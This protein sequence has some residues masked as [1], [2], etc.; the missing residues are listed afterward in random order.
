M[1]AVEDRVWPEW[2]AALEITAVF[3]LTYL[4]GLGRGFIKDDFAWIASNQVTGAG[5]LV[6]LFT[7]TADFYR[8]V[9]RLSFAADWWL[10]GVEPLAYGLT[11]LAILLA[12]AVVLRALALA[13]GMPRGAA[14][15]R[16]RSL[17]LQLPRHGHDAVLDQRAH[18]AAGDA[19]RASRR[20]VLRRRPAARRRGL[21]AARVDVE[22]GC[23]PAA[24]RALR[25]GWTG[26]GER[27]RRDG[28]LQSAPRAPG[29]LAA[30]RVAGP[31]PR[32]RGPPRGR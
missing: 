29:V 1:N 15:P 2:R 22:G 18:V 24:V 14:P 17:G 5:E 21:D 3:L 31:L 10:F 6:G 26:S 27:P 32:G 30:L 16:R 12:A 25:L 28:R 7:G 11:N 20:A 19:V 23:G 8:P 9:V 13:L 4:P